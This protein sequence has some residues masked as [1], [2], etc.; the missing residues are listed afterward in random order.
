[1]SCI[2][3]LKYFGHPQNTKLV[4]HCVYPLFCIQGF[5]GFLEN[6]WTGVHEILETAILVYFMPTRVYTMAGVIR[7]T[8]QCSFHILLH[9][10]HVALAYEELCE[11]LFRGVWWRG[12]PWWITVLVSSGT[13]T[14]LS[15]II[16]GTAIVRHLHISAT[17]IIR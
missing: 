16:H 1:M 2:L 11:E 17:V 14:S 3:G 8:V 5:S 9:V 6:W 13:A 15:G 10:L 4:L 7:N 12:R